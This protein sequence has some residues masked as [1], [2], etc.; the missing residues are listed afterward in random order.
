MLEELTLGKHFLNG[1]VRGTEQRTA[2]KGTPQ[3]FY[4][5]RLEIH[6]HMPLDHAVI[7]NHVQNGSEFDTTTFAHTQ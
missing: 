4:T 3:A 6:A 7:R 1:Y 5:M 2:E